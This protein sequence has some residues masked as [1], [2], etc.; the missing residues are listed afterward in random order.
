[1]EITSE[2]L[3]FFLT[4]RGW[5][6]SDADDYFQLVPPNILNLPENYSLFIKKII[7]GIDKNTYLRNLI[8]NIS[9]IYSIESDELFRMI[10]AVST[11]FS[12]RVYDSKNHNLELTRFESLLSNFSKLLE[13]TAAFVLSKKPKLEEDFH[14]AK[15]YL[16]QCN[17]LKTSKGSFIAKI[18]LPSKGILRQG[19][20]FDNQVLNMDVNVT[21]EKTL[22]LVKETM[23]SSDNGQE[24]Y[25][26]IISENKELINLDMLEDIKDVYEETGIE[27]ID[28]SFN[29]PDR[30]V[31]VEME[32]FDLVKIEN[33]DSFIGII[34]QEL[35]DKIYEISVAHGIVYTLSSKDPFE[36]KNKIRVLGIAK[37]LSQPITVIVKL[38]SDQY[39]KAIDAHKDKKQISL[40]GKAV[41]RKKEYHVTELESIDFGLKENK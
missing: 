4:N 18:E 26:N 31:T 32:G 24:N 35:E 12:I 9:Q 10:T 40:S 15:E 27:N 13:D 39:S 20:L 37:G 29:Y 22:S 38:D 34:R 6:L 14:E 21:L 30:D 28:Y 23:F 16:S 1:M 36:D 33:L 5:S 19:G 41:K 8:K 11:I 3:I 25:R 7:E 2:Q 17:F